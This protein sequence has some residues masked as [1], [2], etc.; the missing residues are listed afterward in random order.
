MLNSDLSPA[1]PQEG[2]EHP[3]DKTHVVS[4]RWRAQTNWVSL[5]GSNTLEEINCTL[6]CC[7]IVNHSCVNVATRYEVGIACDGGGTMMLCSGVGV[8]RRKS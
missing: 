2:R 5:A 8:E 3:T 4:S 6:Q 7:Y 1:A